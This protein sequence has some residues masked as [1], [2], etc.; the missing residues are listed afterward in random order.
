[1]LRFLLIAIPLI[2][3]TASHAWASTDRQASSGAAVAFEEGLVSL[4]EGNAPVLSVLEALSEAAGI[5]IFLFEPLGTERVRGPA[6]GMP[7]EQ[8]LGSVLKGTSHA[9]LY[10]PSTPLSVSTPVMTGS[11]EQEAGP[12][13]TEHAGGDHALPGGTGHGIPTGT[14]GPPS[15]IHAV[16]SGGLPAEVAALRGLSKT[17][18]RVSAPGVSGYGFSLNAFPGGDTAP[19]PASA[20]ASVSPGV[21]GVASG[22]GAPKGIEEKPPEEAGMQGPT[23]PPSDFVQ[24]AKAQTYQEALA[25]TIAR[26]EARIQSG[27]SDVEYARWAQV[28][29]DGYVIHDRDRLAYY[30]QLQAGG[31]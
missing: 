1:M 4:R 21:P 27:E 10:G 26:L 23:G 28:R 30:Q 17:P 14:A 16:A 20:T 9:V 3:G 19:A 24:K 31:L 6:E 2:L 18:A 12:G 13:V 11:S 25:D 8:F 5:H 22:S 7:L 29:G 15:R